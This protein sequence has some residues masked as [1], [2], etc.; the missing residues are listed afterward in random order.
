MVTPASSA[1]AKY[2]LQRNIHGVVAAFERLWCDWLCSTQRAP[3]GAVSALVWYACQ[4]RL[5]FLACGQ[6]EKVFHFTPQKNHQGTLGIPRAYVFVEK[7][8]RTGRG[9]LVS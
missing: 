5:G 2:Q 6:P 1:G 3:C 8:K 4:F 9:E 7:K